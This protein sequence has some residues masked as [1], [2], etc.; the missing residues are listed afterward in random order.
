MGSLRTRDVHNISIL[1]LVTPYIL[2]I[3]GFFCC[4]VPLHIKLTVYMS[5]A[6]TYGADH[7][8]GIAHTHVGSYFKQLIP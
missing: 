8:I 1:H 6:C 5:P 3:F 4:A 2:T 7:G